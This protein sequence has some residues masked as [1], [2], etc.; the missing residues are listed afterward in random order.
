MGWE[1]LPH[2]PYS[3]KLSPCDYHLFGLQK[4]DLKGKHFSSDADVTEAVTSWLGH[5]QK[6][7]YREAIYYLPK[8]WDFCVRAGG[9][10][11]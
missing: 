7:G 4:K 11:F 2:P 9:N 8:R 6:E 1:V 5:F 10:Y 3:P